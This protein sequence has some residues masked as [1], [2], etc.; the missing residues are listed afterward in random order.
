MKLGITG[1]LHLT[2][3]TSTDGL[4]VQKIARDLTKDLDALVV[5]GDISVARHLTFHLD[6]LNEGASCPVYFVLGNHDRWTLPYAKAHEIAQRYPGYLAGKFQELTPEVCL[7]GAN[8]WFDARL[9]NLRNLYST[10]DL[11]KIPEL[12]IA[13]YVEG[14]LLDTLRNWASTEALEL[15]TLLLSNA[16]RY[17]TVKRVIVVTHYPP[18]HNEDDDPI[19]YP[20]SVSSVMGDAL[21]EVAEAWPDV[22]F[23]VM[24]GHTHQEWF[25]QVAPNLTLTTG[26]AEYGQPAVQRVIDLT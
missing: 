1:D 26:K 17:D 25:T 16:E 8:G 7:V 15:K 19:Y 11:L 10:N 21:E 18:W 4:L 12:Q 22:Q 9:G 23:D 13:L 2:H 14:I 20:W 3:V 5:C 24:A 6:N